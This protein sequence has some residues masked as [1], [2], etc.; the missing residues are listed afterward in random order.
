MDAIGLAKQ[1]RYDCEGSGDITLNK[2][3]LRIV[4]DGFIENWVVSQG[5]VRQGFEK[6]K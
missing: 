5:K 1:I 2:E 6:V 4:L 3:T